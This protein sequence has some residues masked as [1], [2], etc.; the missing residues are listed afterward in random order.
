MTLRTDERFTQQV[1]LWQFPCNR[2]IT[3]LRHEKSN[4]LRNSRTTE[5]YF[6]K[7]FPIWNNSTFSR[8]NRRDTHPP[9]VKTYATLGF[10]W[11]RRD[12][13][14]SIHLHIHFSPENPLLW[15]RKQNKNQWKHSPLFWKQL[16]SRRDSN[17]GP[18]RIKKKQYSILPPNPFSQILFSLFRFRGLSSDLRNN[19]SPA[20][21]AVISRPEVG[22]FSRC[23]DEW[24]AKK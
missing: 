7:K 18:S 21:A 24:A 23:S 1:R 5:R 9:F 13:L 20:S 12:S 22:R 8:E 16:R 17:Q 6:S 2:K 15:S 4:L 14:F 3:F 10:L 19:S 11:R